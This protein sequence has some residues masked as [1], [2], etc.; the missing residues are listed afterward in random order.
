MLLQH[1]GLNRGS[2]LNYSLGLFC[3]PISLD[4]FSVQM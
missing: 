2:N 3:F 1:G 4:Y